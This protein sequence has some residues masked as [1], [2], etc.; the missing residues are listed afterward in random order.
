[1]K[2]SKVQK[3]IRGF[4]GQRAV[5]LGTIAGAIVLTC[6]AVDVTRAQGDDRG[7]GRPP[8]TAG[9]VFAMTNSAADNE[10]IAFSR[11][12]DGTLS[13]PRRYTTRGNGQGVD[14]DTQ[15]GL[16][17]S[18]DNRYLYACNPG[19][20]DVTVF[21]VNGNKLKLVQKV[22]AGDQPTSITLSGNLAYVLDSS[23][24]GNGITGFTVANGRLTPIT[25]S[26]QALSS[27]IAVPGEVR[28]TPNGQALVVTH[29][30]G[31]AFDV[32]RI[33]AGRARWRT[34]GECLIR[35]AP[36]RADLP[37]RRAHV[38]GRIRFADTREHGRFVL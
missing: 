4:A 38:G 23:V 1:M 28:F 32:F 8:Q 15:G 19:S 25:D 21:E 26:F 9:A 22:Y 10:V 11:A 14:F 31:S 33:G 24:A 30:V 6:A 20:D 17:L 12:A 16:T 27:P 36:F 35:T 13:Q 5:R 18:S 29:K 7:Q 34:D 3:F 37:Q 2:K